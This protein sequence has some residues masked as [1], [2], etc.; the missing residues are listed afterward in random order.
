[1]TH[2]RPGDSRKRRSLADVVK[3]E[4]ETAVVHEYTCKYYAKTRFQATGYIG[5]R[6]PKM[7]FCLR[8]GAIRVI[9]LRKANP[10]EVKCYAET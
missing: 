1:L 3:F 10:R 9:S 5:D 8:E 4:W 7:V 2:H 6:L